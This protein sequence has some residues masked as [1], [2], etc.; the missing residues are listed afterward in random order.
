MRFPNSS[1]GPFKIITGNQA[2]FL[3]R[4]KNA[5]TGDP[6]DLTGV[7]DIQT[8]FLN[9]DGTELMLGIQ[10]PNSGIAVVG[11]PVIGKI[12]ITLT[13]A[14]TGLAASGSRGGP[15]YFDPFDGLESCPAES[16]SGSDL[17]R[18]FGSALELL[19]SQVQTKPMHRAACFTWPS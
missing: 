11:N 1:Q 9:G 7:Y 15:G 4:L 17:R 16:D 6:Y 8:C 5:V 14:Q 2:S 12:Q 18:V 3:V 13:A 10:A 19:T